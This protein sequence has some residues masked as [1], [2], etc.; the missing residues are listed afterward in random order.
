MLQNRDE[1][2]QL[3][4]SESQVLS[5][6]YQNYIVEALTHC[7]VVTNHNDISILLQE[8][9]E[10]VQTKFQSH[11]CSRSSTNLSAPVKHKRV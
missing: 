9:Q 11:Y 2:I 1:H 4:K 5:N 6:A 10:H 7:G 3:R 8:I